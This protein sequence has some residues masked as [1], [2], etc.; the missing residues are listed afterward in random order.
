MLTYIYIYIY[1]RE[2][3][4]PQLPSDLLTSGGFSLALHA[5][6]ILA[7][8]TICPSRGVSS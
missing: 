6:I 1:I 7:C 2:L 4:F 5:I 3:E 8:G